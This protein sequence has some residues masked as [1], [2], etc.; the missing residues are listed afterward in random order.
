MIWFLILALNVFRFVGLE[1]SP[2]GF[3]IDEASNAAHLICLSRHGEDA[4]GVKWPLFSAQFEPGRQELAKAGEVPPLHLYFGAIWVSMFGGGVYSIRAISAFLSLMTT[5]GI[6]L[7]ARLLIGNQAAL[8]AT[9]SASLSPWLYQLGRFSGM[10]A[11]QAPFVIFS[12]FLFLRARCF[13]LSVL[14]GL[15]FG[16][17]FYSYP[18]ARVQLVLL[19]PL[20]LW[21]KFKRSELNK[22]FLISFLL[23]CF[24][25]LLPLFSYLRSSASMLR[26][27]EI[28]IFG[29][30]Y[31]KAHPNEWIPLVIVR[32]FLKQ[33]SLYFDPN[34]LFISG[35]IINRHSIQWVGEWSWLDLISVSGFLVLVLLKRRNRHSEIDLL[36]IGGYLAGLVPAALTQGNA[37]ALRSAGSI[38]FLCI[39]TGLNLFRLENNTPRL[40]ALFTLTGT[41][42]ACFFIFHLFNSYPSTVRDWWHASLHEKAES[43]IRSHNWYRFASVVHTYPAVAARYYLVRDNYKS[44]QESKI[45]MDRLRVMDGMFIPQI[46]QAAN[47]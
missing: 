26:V 2:P 35:D 8:W 39:W 31:L 32:G 41:S 20:L 43:S 45:F 37:H 18:P 36:C 46:Y 9:L 16:L 4:N 6:Y 25:T 14:A 13:Y 27:N 5:F 34:Y 38:P 30:A 40:K 28:S 15:V 10:S 44:C 1:S 21:L 11:F 33:L 22:R 19:F 47:D 24:I 12:V 23:P 17:S 3:Y 42:F 7:V 29:S